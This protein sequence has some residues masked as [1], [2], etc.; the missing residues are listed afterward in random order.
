MAGKRKKV[1]ISSISRDTIKELAE[2][3]ALDYEHYTMAELARMYGLTEYYFKKAI[4]RAITE[5]IVSDAS[6]RVW[7]GNRRKV[8]AICRTIITPT[9]RWATD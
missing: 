9:E 7:N 2:R 1:D 6:Y 5:C 8:V 4:S 3:Y